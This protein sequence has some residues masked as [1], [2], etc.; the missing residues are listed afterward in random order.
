[1]TITV[2]Q[3]QK[4]LAILWGIGALVSFFLMIWVTFPAKIFK[5]DDVKDTWNWLLPLVLPFLTLIVSSVVAEA[6]QHNPSTAPTNELAFGIAWWL[7]LVYLIL[8]V[9][10]ELTVLWSATQTPLDIFKG[11]NLFLTPIQ[12][13]LGIALGFFFTQRRGRA[14]NPQPPAEKQPPAGKNGI[15]KK[16][17]KDQASSKSNAEGE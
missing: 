12:G 17:K 7:S 11:S 10:M 5:A 9:V 6:N 8:I 16:R 4:R 13:L 2:N 15:Q 14:R 3:A 1:M